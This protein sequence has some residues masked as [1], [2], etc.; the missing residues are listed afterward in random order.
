M[1]YT[2]AIIHCDCCHQLP[3]ICHNVDGSSPYTLGLDQGQEGLRRL[4]ALPW[5]DMALTCCAAVLTM[6]AAR[7]A[8]RRLDSVSAALSA[9]GEQQTISAVRDGPPSA[10]CRTL[11]SLLS[12]YGTCAALP[13]ASSRHASGHL[14]YVASGNCLE[15]A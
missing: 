3:R 14:Q 9:V 8:K 11:V 10:S 13:T 5:W 2:R 15:P 1:T 6:P 4:T 12:R 7:A